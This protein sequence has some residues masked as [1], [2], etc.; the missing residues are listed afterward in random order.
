MSFADFII[1]VA[2]VADV[3]EDIQDHLCQESQAN[4]IDLKRMACK[5]R[6]RTRMFIPLRKPRG[7][8]QKFNESQVMTEEKKVQ[9]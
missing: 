7:P 1:V 4:S 5:R 8:L 9:C 2:R 3:L 6:M